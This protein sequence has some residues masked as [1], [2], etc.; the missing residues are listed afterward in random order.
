MRMINATA[1]NAVSVAA[2]QNSSAYPSARYTRVS[3][4][5]QVTGGA[6]PSGTMKIQYSDD[7]PPSENLIMFFTPTNWYD[8]P[9][10]T[11]TITANGTYSIPETEVAY[12][13]LRLAYAKTSGTGTLT[14][15][16]MANGPY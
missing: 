11:T 5:A 3:A 13:F 16:I 15:Q 4:T 2:D 10:A 9:N 1:L 14:A 8:V 12:R 7:V 6:S